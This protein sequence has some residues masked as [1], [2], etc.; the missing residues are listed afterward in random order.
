M[1]FTPVAEREVVRVMKEKLCYVAPNY[2][3]ATSMSAADERD[4]AC[5]Y[6][7]PDGQVITIGNERF[8]CPEALFQPSMVGL[9]QQGGIHNLLHDS[10]RKCDLDIRRLFLKNIVLA[11]G[12]S[13]FEGMATRLTN[14]ISQ[15]APPGV[16]VNVCADV[17]R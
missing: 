6:E 15:L 16:D 17:D 12:S 1:G 2:E 14:E 4:C 11:G 3:K 9:D 5:E 8:K 7:L 10:V 13:M